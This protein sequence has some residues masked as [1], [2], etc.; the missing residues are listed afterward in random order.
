MV[1]IITVIG[2]QFGGLLGGAVITE[3]VFGLP[4]IGRYAVNAINNLDMPAVIG[5]T[6]LFSFLYVLVNLLVDITYSIID[7]RI[8]Y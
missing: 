2:L 7:P 1:P 3:T 8:R 6:L 4:G 5:S